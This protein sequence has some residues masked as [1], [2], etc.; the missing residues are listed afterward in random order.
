MGA[1]SATVGIAAQS[2]APAHAD[3]YPAFHEYHGANW[4]Q[5]WLVIQMLGVALGAAGA[6]VIHRARVA[7]AIERGPR[8]TPGRRLLAAGSG[9]VVMAIGAHVG[10]GCTSSQILSG[11]SVLNAGS[12]LF[13]A[14]VFVGGYATAPLVRRLW[15]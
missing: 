6:L 11:G 4:T 3:A 1:V 8:C 10:S 13:M 12:W 14:M 9:G 15:Q 7:P 5:E 2:I